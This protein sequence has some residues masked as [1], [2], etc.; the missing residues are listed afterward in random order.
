MDIAKTQTYL[1]VAYSSVYLNSSIIQIRRCLQRRSLSN[2]FR[3]AKPIK[4]MPSTVKRVIFYSLNSKRFIA[5]TSN[6]RGRNEFEF[7]SLVIGYQPG[8]PGFHPKSSLVGFMVYKVALAWF[9]LSTLV[10]PSDF[11]STNCFTFINHPIIGPIYWIL[12]V[13]LK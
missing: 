10:S 12:T 9:S 8:R 5:N 13:S 11:H 7:R 1:C 3:K 6:R 4:R 2:S